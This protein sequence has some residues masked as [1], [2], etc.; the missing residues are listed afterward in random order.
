MVI[1]CVGETERG[2]A[3]ER[4]REGDAGGLSVSVD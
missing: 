3:V 2:L 4:D 1:R